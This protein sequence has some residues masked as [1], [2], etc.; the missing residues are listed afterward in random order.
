MS[1]GKPWE[2]LNSDMRELLV[3]TRN[4][5]K[6]EEIK[7]LLQDLPLKITSLS[8]YSDLPKI[9]E[10]GKTFYDNAVKKAVT[11]SRITKKL[12]MGEDSGLEVEAL[13]NEPGVFSARYA[14]KNATDKKNNAKLLKKLKDVPLQKRKARYRCFV[15]LA[16]SKGIVD[17]VSGSCKGIIALKPEGHN[18]FGYDPLFFFSRHKKTFG[19]LD[20]R[21][22]AKVSHRFHALKK[23]K[24]LIQKYYQDYLK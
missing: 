19:Q 3:A 7:D 18:G 9:I 4:K 13:S 16:D 8:D 6:L 10:D 12:T 2:A 14:G 20:P 5:K 22:K 1:R 17:V 21:L 11:I 15:A 24:I 23:F